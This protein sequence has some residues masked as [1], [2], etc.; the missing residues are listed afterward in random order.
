MR[1]RCH[2]CQPAPSSAAVRPFVCHPSGPPML[3]GCWWFSFCRQSCSRG[4]LQADFCRGGSSMCSTVGSSG[5]GLRATGHCRSGQ[6]RLVLMHRLLH[7]VQVLQVLMHG[8]ESSSGQLWGAVPTA[9]HECS[10]CCSL[11]LGCLNSQKIPAQ[12][13]APHWQSIWLAWRHWTWPLRNT[14]F[15][16]P[17]V[18]P[19]VAAPHHSHVNSTQSLSQGAAPWPCQRGCLG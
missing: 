11:V 14:T 13:T 19:Q 3:L 10:R 17:C 1:A 5:C 7:E 12:V 4:C 16:P 9:H 8:S 2:K 6:S 18:H 15:M